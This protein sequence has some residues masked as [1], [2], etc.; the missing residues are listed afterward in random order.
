M[1]AA[2]C[3]FCI[4]LSDLNLD[5]DIL[6]LCCLK[7]LLNGVSKYDLSCMQF[8]LCSIFNRII[9]SIKCNCSIVKTLQQCNATKNDWMLKLQAALSLIICLIKES[10][11]RLF[12]ADGPEQKFWGVGIPKTVSGIFIGSADPVSVN[13]KQWYGRKNHCPHFY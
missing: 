3:I 10:L 5:N 9:N 1:R 4:R 6:K 2:W 12:R 7:Y 11:P 8:T 13:Y